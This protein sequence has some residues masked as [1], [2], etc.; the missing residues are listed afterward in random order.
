MR[1]SGSPQP[2]T[3]SGAV[4]IRQV[5]Q[6]ARLSAGTWY[7]LITGTMFLD[8]RAE[9]DAWPP[10]GTSIPGASQRVP[11]D[12]HGLERERGKFRRARHGIS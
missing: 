5:R 6:P 8:H 2:W 9:G 10:A 7:T 3:C 1:R 4:G 11:G 12:G